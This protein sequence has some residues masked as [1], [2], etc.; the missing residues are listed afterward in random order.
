[1]VIK[2]TILISN[3]WVSTLFDTGASHSFISTS[4]AS[5]VG[6]QA[7]VLN[8]PFNIYSPVEFSFTI[9]WVVRRCKVEIAGFRFDFDLL[10]FDMEEFDAI[11][12]VDWLSTFRA[13]IDCYRRRIEFQTADD[14]HA[15]VV[16]DRSLVEEGSKGIDSLSRL[17]ARSE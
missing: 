4:F 10:L 15:Y 11:L 1:M 2:G 6:S 16:G 12:G 7:E 17:L 9:Q 5:S 13:T 3:T 14:S 8:F